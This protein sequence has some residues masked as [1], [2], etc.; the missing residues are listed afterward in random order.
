MRKINVFVTMIVAIGM[1]VTSC[2]KGVNTNVS[3][4]SD[5]DSALYAIGVNYGAG[6]REGL[7]TLPGIERYSGEG[8]VIYHGTVNY[9]AV[10]AGFAAAMKDEATLKM[11]PENAQMY[12]QTYLEEVSIREAEAAR[13]EGE[14][15]LASNRGKEGVITTESGLQY[16]VITEGSGRKPQEGDRVI[17]H[18]TG[19]LLDGTVFDSSFT[20]GS[21]PVTFGVMQ[22]IEGWGLALQ[23][24]PVGSKYII[25]VPSNLAYGEY[26]S[27]PLIK[28]NAT[29]EF[30]LELLGIEENS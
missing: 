8:V 17:V 5:V 23:L 29:L 14:A 7:Q 26:G 2:G 1:I 15:F 4:K 22:V 18:Y 12:I 9:D 21:E 10:I 25:W 28:P 19:R 30:E 24:M 16:K 27:P 13:A 3:L 20:Y 11:A 6:L